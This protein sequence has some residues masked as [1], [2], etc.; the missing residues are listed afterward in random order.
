VIA[1]LAPCMARAER[2][3]N[4]IF[5][6]ADDLGYGDLGS[7]GQ[8]KIKTP[9]L[10][11]MAAEGMRFTQHYA[12]TAVCAPSRCALLTGRHMGH[13]AVRD[14]QERG[15]GIEGQQPM[16]PE[17]RTIAQDLQKAG[18]R[19]G[20][21]GKWG[22]GMPEDRS[23]PGDFGFDHSYGYLCQR[24]AHSF[25]PAY[26]WRDAQ[27]EVLPGNTGERLATGQTYAH[28]LLAAD[29]LSFVRANRERPFFL[30]LA[31]TIPH[32]A[33]QVPEDSLAEYRGRFEEVPYVGNYAPQPTPRAAY[34]A[35]ITRMDRD[36]GRLFALLKELSLDENTVV[37]F[38]SDNGPTLLLRER[39]AEFFQSAAG[40]RGLKQD[41]Y[42]GGIRVPLLA[43]WPGR[44]AAGTT[45]N[46]VSAFW[47][48]APTLAELAGAAPPA[49]TD[50]ISFAPALLGAPGQRAHDALYWEYHSQGGSQAVRFGD[51]KAIR[52]EVKKSPEPA[53]E[54]YDLAKDPGEANDLA[55]EHPGL[56]ARSR[57]LM[58]QSRTPSAN[59]RWNFAAEN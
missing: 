1:S 22:L 14:N 23:G 40:L 47:D 3:P 53:V 4:I 54:L 51:W 15:K 24:H 28:D 9:H 6:L 13:A 37:F 17:T 16:P 42:E 34:A 55:A 41:L 29:A 21:V 10:D 49:E 2:K 52:R 38:S 57:A 26:L 36:I 20:I 48:L 32:F 25:F 5:I 58:S 7:Y 59:P 27:K 11:R 45:S 56:V 39:L 35:M 50:G 12:G 43:R 31:F 18:Y 46:H 19:T 30:Y 33:L 44:I 8:T